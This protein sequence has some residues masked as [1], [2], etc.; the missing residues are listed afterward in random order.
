M[1]RRWLPDQL[2]ERLASGFLVALLACMLAEAIRRHRWPA[3]E[4]VPL[5]AACGCLVWMAS[6][7]MAQAAA[8]GKHIRVRHLPPLVGDTRRR[9]FSFFADLVFFL[10]AFLS[11]IA[12]SAALQYVLAGGSVASHPLVYAAIPVGSVFTMIR[13]YHRLRPASEGKP[14]PSIR[15]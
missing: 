9:Q 3:L 1:P 2:E 8:D 6:M 14:C 15:D 7:G 10:F 11:C 5:R 4:P 13:L 12:G